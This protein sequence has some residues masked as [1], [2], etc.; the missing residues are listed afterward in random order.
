MKKSI[1]KITSLATIAAIAS[2]W[3]CTSEPTENK[4][5]VEITD[6]TQVMLDTSLYPVEQM[7]LKYV[8]SISLT[9]SI[10]LVE[11]KT[12]DLKSE[13][14]FYRI[15]EKYFWNKLERQEKYK[16]DLIDR[17]VKE[18]SYNPETKEEELSYIQGLRKKI[19][20]QFM[21]HHELADTVKDG[22]HDAY[23]GELFKRGDKIKN[24]FNHSLYKELKDEITT[25]NSESILNYRIAHMQAAVLVNQQVDALKP[26]L[27]AQKLDTNKIENLYLLAQ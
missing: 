10:V 3:S 11:P 20:A 12:K 5:K 19:K 27:I 24:M 15:Q 1:R 22:V 2:L 6:S 8:D 23:L 13:M 7:T 14:A 17:L 9:D 26:K 18:I 25:I 16:F 21:M 4:T